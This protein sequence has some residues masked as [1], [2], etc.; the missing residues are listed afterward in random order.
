MQNKIT[1]QNIE[2]MSTKLYDSIN[3]I[4]ESENVESHAIF[5][6]R[7]LQLIF[8]AKLEYIMKLGSKGVQ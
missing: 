2:S 5:I 1:Q 3:E 6:A 4:L 8:E 7:E